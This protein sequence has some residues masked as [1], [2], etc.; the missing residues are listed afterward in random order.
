VSGSDLTGEDEIARLELLLAE[1]LR[2]AL[3][4]RRNAASEKTSVRSVLADACDIARARALYPE[5]VIIMLKAAWTRLGDS[6]VTN[7]HDAQAALDGAVAVCIQEYF[8]EPGWD[9]APAA[10]RAD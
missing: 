10:R 5:Q 6:G 9:G 4:A 7:Q 2:L 1:A 3:L 8:A